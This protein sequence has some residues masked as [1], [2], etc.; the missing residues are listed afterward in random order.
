M[1][2]GT[3]A[4]AVLAL[5][6]LT[7]YA[8]A[9]ELV[10][11]EPLDEFTFNGSSINGDYLTIG[12]VARVRGGT[13]EQAGQVESIKL[14]PAPYPGSA[15]NISRGMLKNRLR[16][17]GIDISKVALKFP[18]IFRVRLPE[19]E[20]SEKELT[21]IIIDA[22]KKKFADVPG[23]LKIELL[24]TPGTLS[25]PAKDPEF[26]VDTDNVRLG[27]PSVVS[28]EVMVKG[29]VVRTVQS[30]IR[31]TLLGKAIV[32]TRSLKRHQVIEPSDVTLKMTAIS[33]VDGFITDPVEAV[34]LRVRRN[35]RQGKILAPALL[36][37]IP[38][39]KRGDKVRIEFRRGPVV[40]TAAGLA[41]GTAGALE[42]VRVRNLSTRKELYGKVK[43]SRCVV[44]SPVKKGEI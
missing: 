2:R 17:A 8:G 38:L 44:V 31:I 35:L 13:E 30:R 4:L 34:G 37:Q 27:L 22:V 18:G 43:N 42:T 7:A 21:T 39:V 29:T 3:T 40:I 20:V 6:A 16:E 28:M 10:T 15:V 32:L 24:G 5:V 14:I 23:K 36:E 41:L 33:G 25:L 19:I 1:V 12:D 26:F 11:I 9:S